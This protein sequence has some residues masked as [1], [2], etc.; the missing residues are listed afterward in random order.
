MN[1]TTVS[2]E[3]WKTVVANHPGWPLYHVAHEESKRVFVGAYELVF[4]CYLTRSQ[5]SE[6][7]GTY[8]ADSTAA[9]A[10]ADIPAIYADSGV[11]AEPRTPSGV[12]QVI[13]EPRVGLEKIFY[14]PNFCDPTTWY[15]SSARVTDESLTDSGDGLTWNSSNV[16]WIDMTHGKVREEDALSALVGHGYSIEVEVDGVSKTQR[17]PFADSGGDFSV[18]Y[19]NGDIIFFE[20]QSG[21]TVTASYSCATDSEFR[22]V[23]NAGK[24]IQIEHAE[25]QFSEDVDFS[26]QIVEFEIWAYDPNDLPNKVPV[27]IDKYK[28]ISNFIDEAV[29]AYPKIPAVGGAYPQGLV[30][31]TIGFPFRYATVRQLVDSSGIELRIRLRAP[32]GTFSTPFIGERGTATFYCTI[33][34]EE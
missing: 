15:P 32:D 6:W 30:Y 27:D 14:T 31:D 8:A 23:P 5:L 24:I 3:Q 18:D 7:D 33:L 26:G 16:N 4:E 12:P 10:A 13:P 2:W 25:A 29:G 22:I 34:D 19:E 1:W 20:S 11:Y 9:G 21:S 17:K 28:S